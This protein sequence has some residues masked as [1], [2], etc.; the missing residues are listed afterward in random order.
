MHNLK[1][2]SGDTVICVNPTGWESLKAGMLMEVVDVSDNTFK[3][4]SP[5]VGEVTVMA[6]LAQDFLRI[7]YV[8][9]ASRWAH[10]PSSPEHLCLTSGLDEP[11]D[12]EFIEEEIAPGVLH[13]DGLMDS[14]KFRGITMKTI[15]RR[16]YVEV[17]E[18]HA[19][20]QGEWDFDISRDGGRV[21]VNLAVLDGL[22]SF[23]YSERYIVC[24]VM[25]HSVRR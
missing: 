7:D 24:N 18:R 17:A 6:E 25:M 4:S 16:T 20:D 19:I 1:I 9:V 11:L 23:G 13:L 14:M 10:G 12:E 2:K 21:S 15:L 22:R 5:L 3:V 8:E